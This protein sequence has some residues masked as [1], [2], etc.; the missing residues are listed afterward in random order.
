MPI[1]EKSGK[2]ETEAFFTAFLDGIQSTILDMG[3]ISPTFNSTSWRFGYAADY[4]NISFNPSSASAFKCLFAGKVELLAMPIS[5]L[6]KALTDMSPPV[7]FENAEDVGAYISQA[8]PETMKELM[9]RGLSI[10]RHLMQELSAQ[11]K[12]NV[13]SCFNIRVCS[14]IHTM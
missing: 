14:L 2:A 11:F 12:Y 1:P 8:N 6:K 5:S 7:E 3:T 4:Q 9:G 10:Y 13:F